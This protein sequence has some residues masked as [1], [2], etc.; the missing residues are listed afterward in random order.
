[1]ENKIKPVYLVI[2]NDRHDDIEIKPFICERT[3]I[4]KAKELAKERTKRPED[5]KEMSCYYSK[6]WLF[7]AEYSCEFD[8]VGVKKSELNEEV[9]K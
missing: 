8:F 6:K 3:A 1:M 9:T 5:Y 7:F 4:K 2:I